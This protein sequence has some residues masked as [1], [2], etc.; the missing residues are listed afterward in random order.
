MNKDAFWIFLNLGFGDAIVANGLLRHYADKYKDRYV[1]LP[2]WIHNMASIQWMLSDVP[3]IF[4]YPI[5]TEQQL[6]TCR[7]SIKV[8]DRLCLGWY[9]TQFDLINK[10]KKDYPENAQVHYVFDKFNPVKWDSEFYRQ[11]GLP[12]SLKWDGFKLPSKM[13]DHSKLPNWNGLFVHEDRSRGFMINPKYLNNENEFKYSYT[14][15]AKDP[16][17]LAMDRIYSATEIHCIDSSMLNLADL[18]ET[19]HCK[20]FVF[21]RYAR[22]GLP[23]TL[24]KNWEIID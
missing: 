14:P 13:A 11:A 23:P 7:D 21:H 20:S 22:K 4:F 8:E 16:I 1:I 15:I 19:P 2:C 12:D 3:N 18:M 9:E 5:E 17:V 6:L 10:C 24:K